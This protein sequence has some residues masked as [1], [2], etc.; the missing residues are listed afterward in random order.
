ME[1]ID[2]NNDDKQ[3]ILYV[4]N[5]IKPL[6]KFVKKANVVDA[7]FADDR[8]FAVRE[9]RAFPC[10]DPASTYLSYCYYQ[11]NDKQIPKESLDYMLKRSHYF[12]ICDHVIDYQKKHIAWERDRIKQASSKNCAFFDGQ[13]RH[14][15][16]SEEF[17]VY[18]AVDMFEKVAEERYTIPQRR[19]IASFIVKKASEYGVNIRS[20]KIDTYTQ[21]I[22]DP[23]VAAHNIA[24]R[25]TAANL[26]PLEKKAYAEVAKG[27]MHTPPADIHKIEKLARCLERMD[28]VFGLKQKAPDYFKSAY[29]SVYN[30]P[31]AH[32][33]AATQFIDLC[34]DRISITQM[35]GLPRELYADALGEE[36]AK[37]ITDQHGKADANKI[38]KIVPTLPLPDKNVLHRYVK[39]HIGDEI[40]TS[41]I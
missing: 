13:T 22:I 23:V 12:G 30:T 7:D 11:H 4:I 35:I 21:N 40:A 39:Q 31:Y 5:K 14:F 29:E 28:E 16:I 20:K 32:I 27:I 9:K 8:K 2:F 25:A 19:T 1:Y 36:F 3:K 6:P 24:A 17:H 34:G 41:S 18:N 10:H 38:A 15:P 26:N 33:K 37:A